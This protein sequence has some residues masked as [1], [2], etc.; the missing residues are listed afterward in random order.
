MASKRIERTFN[1]ISPKGNIQ[2]TFIRRMVPCVGAGVVPE[3]IVWTYRTFRAAGCPIG[4]DTAYLPHKS[5]NQRTRN[6]VMN[7]FK[8]WCR[9]TIMMNGD[10]DPATD[11][12]IEL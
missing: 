5:M 2:Y 6:A 10:F 3:V 11:K 7:N 12:V 9:Q 1:I 8:L 4:G